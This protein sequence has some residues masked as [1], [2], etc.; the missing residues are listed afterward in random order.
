MTEPVTT[1]AWRR[2]MCIGASLLT[3]EGKD[4]PSSTQAK[5]RRR[6]AYSKYIIYGIADSPQYMIFLQPCRKKEQHCKRMEVLHEIGAPCGRCETVSHPPGMYRRL[7]IS[8]M[9]SY[10][11]HNS[12]EKISLKSVF[13]DTSSYRAPTVAPNGKYRAPTTCASGGVERGGIVA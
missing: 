12:L 7:P 1:A 13:Q 3:S 8:N 6:A 2:N 4:K 11:M 5:K 10:R 9:L